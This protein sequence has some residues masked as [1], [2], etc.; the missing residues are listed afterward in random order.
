MIAVETYA[1]RYGFLF[2][3]FKE[4]VFY[5]ELVVMTRKLVVIFGV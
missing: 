1:R 3:G 5:W 2:M 4:K